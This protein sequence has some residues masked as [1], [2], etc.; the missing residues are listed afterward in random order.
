MAQVN[1]LYLKG[2]GPLIWLYD[3]IIW[4]QIILQKTNPNKNIYN[5]S[6]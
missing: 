4:Y 6:G 1:R 5:Y 3:I 2:T